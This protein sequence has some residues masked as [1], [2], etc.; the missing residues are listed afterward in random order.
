MPFDYRWDDEQKT[1]IYVEGIGN[2]TWD[3]FHL[4]TEEVMK[5]MKG[6]SHRVDVIIM[7]S[8]TG[9]TPKGSGIPH[10]QRVS[11]IFPDNFGMLVMVGDNIMRNLLVNAMIRVFGSGDVQ[12][13]LA[14]NLD[15][16]YT[17][18]KAVREADKETQ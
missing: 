3:E 12:M 18:I 9:R 17:I 4:T 14:N 11:R 7:R 1:V 2:W 13:H 16:A 10:Y 8:K 15:E 6:V 5:M